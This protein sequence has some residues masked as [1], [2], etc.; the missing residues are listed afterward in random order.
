MPLSGA[1]SRELLLPVPSPRPIDSC[2]CS[3]ARAAN[4]VIF[5]FLIFTSAFVEVAA[6]LLDLGQW[7]DLLWM[8]GWE[9]C[10]PCCRIGKPAEVWAVWVVWAVGCR[11]VFC[12]GECSPGEFLYRRG[13]VTDQFRF[14]LANDRLL[15]CL[16]YVTHHFPSYLCSA[17]M[18]VA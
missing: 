12:E 9:V 14:F 8:G 1:H 6:D 3:L 16:S 15:Y 11:M 4:M 10:Q 2:V 13:S 5:A 18:I 7:S 17:S